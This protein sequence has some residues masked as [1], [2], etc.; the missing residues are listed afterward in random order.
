MYSVEKGKSGE[1]EINFLPVPLI[2]PSLR[3]EPLQITGGVT[4]PKKILALSKKN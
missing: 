2:A 1:S 3:G 4:F